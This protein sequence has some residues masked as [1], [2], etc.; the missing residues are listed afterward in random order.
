MDEAMKPERIEQDPPARGSFRALEEQ[1][2][3]VVEQDGVV[4]LSAMGARKRLKKKRSTIREVVQPQTVQPPVEDVIEA[5]D[6]AA[7][8]LAIVKHEG[9]RER[10]IPI[11]F[12]ERPRSAYVVSLQSVLFDASQPPE[13]ERI[14]LHEAFD[15]TRVRSHAGLPLEVFASV[16]SDL[17][18]DLSGAKT[19]TDQFTANTFE[20]TYAAVYGRFDGVRR[21]LYEASSILTGMFQ[22]VERI[23]HRAVE[24]F[25]ES[26]GFTE[27][28][29]LSFARALAGFVGLALI[30]TLPA[31][32]VALYRVASQ[33]KVEA[34][35][36][37]SQAVNDILAAKDATSLPDSADALKQA[38][39]R[40]READSYLSESSALAI[41]IAS[42][43]PKQYRSARALL[44][45][46]DKSSEAAALLAQGF[47]KIFSEPDRRLDERLEV[48]GAYARSSLSLLKDAQKAAT[49]VDPES[50]PEAQRAQVTKL[51]AELEKGT[52]AVQECAALADVM[53]QMVGKD[54][55]RKYLVIF[56]NH[57]EL[58]PTGGFMGSFA[59]LTFDQG[60]IRDIQV[61]GG[62]TYDLKGQLT[63]RVASPK[64]LQL[65]NPVW[66]FQ[67]SNWSPDFPTSAEEIRW[68]WSK[69]GQPT[70]DGIIAINASFVEKLLALTGPIEMPE[71]GKTIDAS[72]F[73]L[74]TQKSVELEYDKTA[75]TPKRFIGDLSDKMRER[76]SNM[77]QDELL[78][79][80]G[81][82][83]EA[84]DT[85]DIQMAFRREAEEQLAE[86]YG[87]NGRLKPAVGDAL[88]VIET[89]IAGQ[90]TDGVIDEE[91]DH[92]VNIREDGTI[93]DTVTLKRS[94]GG[95][96]GELFKGVRNVSY[97]R[98]YVPRGSRLMAASGF[99][100]PDPK[101]F[102]V[103]DADVG[104]YPRIAEVEATQRLTE[105]GVDVSLENDRTVFGGWLQLDPGATDEIRLT[106]RLPFT[107]NELLSRLEETSETPNASSAAY[108]LLLTSQSGKQN[109]RISTSV[110]APASWDVAWHKDGLT[111]DASGVT[112]ASTP[113]DRDKVVA[114]LLKPHGE[115]QKK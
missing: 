84:L 43:L 90:K 106:Y 104:S 46:G 28:P 100:P 92:Q 75:N 29:R 9:G 54:S 111:A 73:L 49:T 45:I 37:G 83:S 96:R 14:S 2:A 3:S 105:Q 15:G 42:V 48:L 52:Q 22:R 74:E 34:T 21:M 55:Q 41:G 25:E 38:S 8:E 27:V 109:R 112:L 68:F 51:L 91:V 115:T 113:W 35:E 1:L 70:I 86:R 24:E 114:L 26:V 76:L 32:A 19:F 99:E 77:K 93:E 82:V 36:V 63:E 65:I 69:S 57:T 13:D 47:D 33:D 80:A 107:A 95:A 56:Q 67:D 23:E 62:G 71:Y 10:A 16:S 18:S 78:R 110:H 98:V 4:M 103:P 50:V 101:L 72:N 7:V 39:G 53:A 59:E 58:R 11:H 6:R 108:L 30:V 81:L 5:I 61:P 94:H 20:E 31:N 79:V 44:E 60:A 85:K 88:A 64:P 87:W 12:E 66:Q 89:N 102:K 40:F 97:L 17:T